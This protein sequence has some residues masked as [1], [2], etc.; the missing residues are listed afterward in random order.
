MATM[1]IQDLIASKQKDM[2]AKKARQSTLKPQP[3]KHTYRILPS[4]RGSDDKQFWHDY[5]MHYVKTGE[6]ADAK[7]DAVYICIEKT[8]GKP[9]EICDAIKKSIAVSTSDSMTK[10]LKDAHAAQRYLMN[11]LHITGGE[12]TKPQVLEVGTGA[13]EAICNLIGE[14]GDITDLQEGIDV[15][16]TRTGAG[17]DTKYTVMPAAKS[18][19]VP[20]SI[21]SS[22][23]NL[24][25]FV[26]QE[27][28]AGETKALTAVGTIIG[29]LPAAQ[30]APVGRQSQAALAS[31]ASEVEDAEFTPVGSGAAEP[32]AKAAP[33][34]DD[35][36]SDLDELLG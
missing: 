26:S 4:W 13:F 1:S 18:N 24:D 10:R 21:M 17:L 35:D 34:I 30:G 20:V 9:C 15:I 28:P 7:P 27:N 14:Y 36:L 11:V 3:G 23:T 2:A 32:A 31:L 29:L 19:P 22:L 25:E 6:N 12:P 8:Y 33:T 16:I 5:A